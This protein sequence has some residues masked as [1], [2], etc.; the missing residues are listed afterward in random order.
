MNLIHFAPSSSFLAARV[1]RLPLADTATRGHVG[2]RT[3]RAGKHIYPSS[4]GA[5]F[6]TKTSRRQKI[7]LG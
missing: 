5:T 2:R 4:A 7:A 3:N 6:R 1:G